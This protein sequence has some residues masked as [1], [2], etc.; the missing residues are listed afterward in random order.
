MKSPAILLGLLLVAACAA[1]AVISDIGDASLKV[2][3]NRWTSETEIA[4][5]AGDGCAL[6]EKEPVFISYVCRDEYCFAREILF[7]CKAP[8]KIATA[9]ADTSGQ[10]GVNTS[11]HEGIWVG[12]GPDDGCGSPWAMRIEVRNG[13]ADGMLWRGKAAYN[14]AGAINHEGRVD[15]MLAGKTAASNGIVGPRFITVNAAF[16]ED[17]ADG[18][19]SMAASGGGE[20]TVPVVLM[21]HQA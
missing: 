16:K 13:E 10:R 6:Y 12:E 1:P 18:D 14:F 5:A 7:A 20:C 11:L 19:Y 8:N 15:K 4:R 21:R 9:S 17:R 2:Q 3:A